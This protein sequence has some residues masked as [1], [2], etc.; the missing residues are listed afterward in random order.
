MD[1]AKINQQ[2]P[3]CVLSCAKL[4][5]LTSLEKL[6]RCLAELRQQTAGGP[7]LAQDATQT[8]GAGGNYGSVHRDHPALQVVSGLGGLVLSGVFNVN[9]HFR[10]YMRYNS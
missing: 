10:C 2:C 4:A 1:T 9:S 8:D 5:P 7:V 6:G 3:G